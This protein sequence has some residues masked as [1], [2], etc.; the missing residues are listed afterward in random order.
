MKS[1]ADLWADLGSL[2]EDELFQ[3]ITRLFTHY[4]TTLGRDPEDAEALGFFKNLDLAI[5]Q[6]SQCNSNRR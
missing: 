2:R 5:T 1:V 6:T 4:E 3:M